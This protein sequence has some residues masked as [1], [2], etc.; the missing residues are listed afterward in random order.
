MRVGVQPAADD[1]TE[2]SRPIVLT[3][4]IDATVDR[5]VDLNSIWQFA[6]QLRDF[7]NQLFFE[8]ITDRTKALFR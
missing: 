2:G 4:D 3:I 5:P 7:K 6:D 1:S 8:S